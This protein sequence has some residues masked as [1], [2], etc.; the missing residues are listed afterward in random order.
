MSMASSAAQGSHRKPGTS[1]PS[2][3]R[4][5]PMPIGGGSE[6]TKRP[7]AGSRS[8]HNSTSIPSPAK[9]GVRTRPGLGGTV[10]FNASRR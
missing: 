9:P 1:L 3:S 4:T 7:N 10:P 5:L 6:A 2:A 8:R